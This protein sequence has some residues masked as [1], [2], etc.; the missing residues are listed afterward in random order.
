MLTDFSKD[1]DMLNHAI[2][3]SNLT[4]ST[5]EPIPTNNIPIDS[6]RQAETHKNFKNFP[7]FKAATGSFSGGSTGGLIGL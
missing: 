3:I 4:F 6:A 5:N 2:V 1:F 7:Y